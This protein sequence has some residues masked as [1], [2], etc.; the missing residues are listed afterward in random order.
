[1][2][3]VDLNVWLLLIE[4]QHPAARVQLPALARHSTPRNLV[5]AVV[6][7]PAAMRAVVFLNG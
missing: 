6:V 2:L 5:A 3:E 1:M 4:H 7:C